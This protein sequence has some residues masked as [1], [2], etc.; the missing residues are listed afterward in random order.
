MAKDTSRLE[1]RSVS[2]DE[3]RTWGTSVELNFGAETSPERID[4]WRAVFD[5]DRCFAVLDGTRIVANSAVYSYD[6][7]LPGAAPQ[8]CAGVTAVGVATDWR[9]RGLL[10]RMM[11]AMLDQSHERGEPF[12]AL[13]ASES[14]IYGRFGFGIAAPHVDH[15]VDTVRARIARPVGTDDVDLVDAA[16]ALEAFPAIYE[17]ARRDRA[18][19]MSQAD[20]QWRIWL[21]HDDADRRDGYSPRFHA[22]VPGRGFVVYRWKDH[23]DHYTPDGSVLVTMLVSADPEAESALWELVFGVDLTVR[24]TARMRPLDDGLPYLVDN[25]A[26]VRDTGAEHLYLRLVDL[27]AA[28]CARGYAGDGTVTV[29]V[30]D[31]LCPWNAGTWRLDVRD[32]AATCERTDGHADLVLDTAD[33]ASLLLGG[34][35]ASQLVWSRRMVVRTPSAVATV[36]RLFAAERAPWNPFEF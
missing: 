13:Y 29:A 28:L 34:V 15:T 5:L 26:L 6:V 36:D 8:P 11:R 10:R 24:L 31:E 2:A 9:R 4:R 7:S 32:G 35:R 12:A 21:E 19:M 33:L 16:T 3:F 27:P 23:F 25:R 18:G 14:T 30:T 17:A 1:L 20:A 22:L